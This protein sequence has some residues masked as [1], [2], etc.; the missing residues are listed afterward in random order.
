MLWSVSLHLL[1]GAIKAQGLLSPAIQKV[2]LS[3]CQAGRIAE[4]ADVV[5]QAIY[6]QALVDRTLPEP[7][8]VMTGSLLGRMTDGAKQLAESYGRRGVLCAK[9]YYPTHQLMLLIIRLW[10]SQ[11][12]S[13][14]IDPS[15]DSGLLQEGDPD[16]VTRCTVAAQKLHDLLKRLPTNEDGDLV[17]PMKEMEGLCMV[18]IRTMYVAFTEPDVAVHELMHGENPKENP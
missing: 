7:K 1:L 6:A 9:G 3:H 18:A 14:L 13:V 11:F 10:E 12:N 5:A 4:V 2:L 16:F 17:L 8:G 15:M